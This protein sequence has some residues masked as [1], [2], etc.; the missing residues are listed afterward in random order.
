M[1]KS[2]TGL[3]RFVDQL[4]LTAIRINNVFDVLCELFGAIRLLGLDHR[5][6]WKVGNV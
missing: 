1:N 6:N 3:V 5:D 4:I 2:R